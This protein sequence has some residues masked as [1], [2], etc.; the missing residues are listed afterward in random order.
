MRAVS[1]RVLVRLEEEKPEI[2]GVLLPDTFKQ[3]KNVGVVVGVGPLVKAVKIG[4][5]ILFHPFD[6]LETLEKNV[7]VVRENSVLGVLENDGA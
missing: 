5:R 6:E 3:E 7:V 4:E 2:C 1:D